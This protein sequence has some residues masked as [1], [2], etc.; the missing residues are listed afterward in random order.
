METCESARKM[1]LVTLRWRDE[2]SCV[3][4]SVCSLTL[5]LSN[6]F[7]QK[8]KNNTH[9]IVGAN[10]KHDSASHVFESFFHLPLTQHILSFKSISR[11]KWTLLFPCDCWKTL[12]HTTN[13]PIYSVIRKISPFPWALKTN[14]WVIN[15]SPEM[16]A[17]QT[18]C[19]LSV[20][21]GLLTLPT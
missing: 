10:S 14:A 19:H 17:P 21:T 2:R 9:H 3:F 12:C 18:H 6:V 5:I 11:S 20:S 7:S 4:V 1:S 8:K 16:T 15:L 13:D